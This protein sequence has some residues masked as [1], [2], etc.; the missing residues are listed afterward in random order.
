MP[1]SPFLTLDLPQVSTRTFIPE[2]FL[3][4]LVTSLDSVDEDP[5]PLLLLGHR[6]DS[7]ELAVSAYRMVRTLSNMCL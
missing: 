5:I 3:M 4:R 7:S 6:R 2:R 1:S